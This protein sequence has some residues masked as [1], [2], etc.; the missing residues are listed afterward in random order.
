MRGIHLVRNEIGTFARVVRQLAVAGAVSGACTTT[1]PR[2]PHVSRSVVADVIVS[3]DNQTS[4]QMTIYL[5]AGATHDSLG[6]VLAKTTRSFSL[7][8]GASDSTNAL[9]LEARERRRGSGV[10]SGSFRLT[11]GHQV[12]WTLESAGT[13]SVTMR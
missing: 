6:V 3:V 5:D 13:T 11:P 8:S 7:P 10:R 2:D 4:R 9:Q 1:D 12:V